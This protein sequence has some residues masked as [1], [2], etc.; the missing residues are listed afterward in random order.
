MWV[1][2]L[3]RAMFTTNVTNVTNPNEPLPTFAKQEAR[4]RG[5]ASKVAGCGRVG[6]FLREFPRVLSRH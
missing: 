2:L 5:R 3:V 1:G 6:I 4:G